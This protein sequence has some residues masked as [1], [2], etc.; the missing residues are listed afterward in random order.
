M[1]AVEQFN[2]DLVYR[3]LRR[4]AHRHTRGRKPKEGFN[5]NSSENIDGHQ[6]EM[7]AD[8]FGMKLE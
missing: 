8:G 3:R 4:R 1:N 5:D 7:K 2:R 6:M